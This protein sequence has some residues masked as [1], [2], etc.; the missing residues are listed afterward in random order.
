MAFLLGKVLNAFMLDHV[1]A[2]FYELERTNR[3]LDDGCELYGPQFVEQMNAK[4]R[5]DQ[6]APRYRVHAMAIHPSED[7]GRIAGDHLRTHNAR[8]GR[9]LGRSMLKMLD[10][11]QGADADLVSY[12]LFDG[13]F[14]RQLMALGESDARRR[15]GDLTQFF[16]GEEG[17]ASLGKAV[18]ESR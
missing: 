10:L 18:D 12:L 13:D 17:V 14:A 8:F 6:R 1:N 5:A 11:G 3:I 15:E 2:D 16:W 9:L 7:I 4:A